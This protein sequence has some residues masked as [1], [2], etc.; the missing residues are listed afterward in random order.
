MAVQV[1][2]ADIAP[3]CP[4]LSVARLHPEE[5]FWDPSLCCNS[6]AAFGSRRRRTST[7]IMLRAEM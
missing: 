2:E 1:G 5:V 4:V 6:E 7:L 3:G